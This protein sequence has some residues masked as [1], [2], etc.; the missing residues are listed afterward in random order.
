MSNPCVGGGGG[1]GEPPIVLP[2]V[3]SGGGAQEAVVWSPLPAATT[4]TSHPFTRAQVSLGTG[5]TVGTIP[6]PGH[7]TAHTQAH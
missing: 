3:Y 1:G 4:A 5:G 2:L 6:T 7:R